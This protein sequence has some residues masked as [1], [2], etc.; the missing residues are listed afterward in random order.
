MKLSK[1]AKNAIMIGAL[2]AVAYLAV[3]VARNVLGAVNPQLLEAGFTEEYI[4]R[5]SSLY[6]I[7]YAVGQLINGLIGNRIHAKYMISLGL[8]LSA[9]SNFVFSRTIATEA[10]A[11]MA[12]AVTGFFLAM[13]YAPMTKVVAE[14]TEP[15][16][17]T[18]CSL[19][20][21]FASLIGSPAAGVLATMM[22]WQDVFD[23]S[24]AALLIMG[25][26]CFLCFSLMERHGIVRY[27]QYQVP[28]K[29]S[30]KG[31][32]KVLLE[33]QIVKF[34]I[35]AILTGVVR[36]SVI[37][38]LPTY[39][40]QALGFNPQQASAIYSVATLL[41]AS[42]AFLSV[43]VYELLGR[44][45]D[46]TLLLMFAASTL[47]F[48]GMFFVKQPFVNIALMVLA[49]I[50]ANAAATMLWSRYCPGLRDTGMVSGATGF[51]DFL[52]YM[53][54]AIANVLFPSAVGVIGWNNLI[55]VWAGL[56]LIGTVISLPWRHWF[57]KK[58]ASES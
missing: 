28:K 45:M 44:N 33:H 23:F 41:I 10:V 47:F 17:A 21:T 18:R 5:I 19:G 36:T 39:I 43:F 15:V 57:P 56:V 9:I 55:L 38:W 2:C 1:N 52:S 51:L 13:I 3:Y 7:F 12:Y 48:L 29:E 32:L 58:T 14:N 46:K 6:F 53:A 54:A 31:S 16:H 30:K 50:G 49:I 27:N 8:A 37:F 20:Y 26:A 24:S 22:V 40:S 11:M 42:A 4:G 35:V 34:S 25:I